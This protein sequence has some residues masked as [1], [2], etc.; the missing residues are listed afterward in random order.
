MKYDETGESLH[1][2][3]NMNYMGVHSTAGLCRPEQ[4]REISCLPLSAFH[5]DWVIDGSLWELV[6]FLTL[7]QLSGLLKELH[8]LVSALCT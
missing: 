1:I 4:A 6:M 5:S 7:V 3:I 8:S 2:L